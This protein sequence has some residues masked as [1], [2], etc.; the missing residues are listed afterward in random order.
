MPHFF[1]KTA[2]R[3]LVDSADAQ[4]LPQ[5]PP[6]E[7]VMLLALIDPAA[8]MSIHEH[9]CM[10]QCPCDLVSLSTIV[11]A[12]KEKC[13][14]FSLALSRGS[15]FLLASLNCLAQSRKAKKLLRKLSN[16]PRDSLVSSK[17]RRLSFAPLAL[18]LDKP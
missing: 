8:S 14:A 18:G 3:D 11:W 10:C 13:L 16:F 17:S 7:I 1:H 12:H 9:P 5:I 2:K 6:G 4:P 15:K